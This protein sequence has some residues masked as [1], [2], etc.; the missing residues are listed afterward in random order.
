MAGRDTPRQFG[1]R[2]A[3]DLFVAPAAVPTRDARGPREAR[4]AARGRR[5]SRLR[6]E[7][8]RSVARRPRQQASSLS[9]A[10]SCPAPARRQGVGTCRTVPTSSASTTAATAPAP[11]RATRDFGAPVDAGGFRELVG[12]ASPPPHPRSDRR[13]VRRRGDQRGATRV[14]GRRGG[15]PRRFLVESSRTPSTWNAASG[16]VVP[17]VRLAAR[18]RGAA[19]VT[20]NLRRNRLRGRVRELV[21]VVR[22]RERLYVVPGG[23]RRVHST[24]CEVAAGGGGGDCRDVMV[25]TPAAA[26]ATSWSRRV[27]VLFGVPPLRRGRQDDGRAADDGRALRRRVPAC[28]GRRSP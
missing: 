12:R 25:G 18:A 11:R 27:H 9:P 10:A 1:G 15:R 14:S 6:N 24:T 17:D 13:R 23:T 19:F 3:A 7:P 26:S 22:P 21:V 20:R 4:A 2:R 28:R 16:E 5:R 8:P